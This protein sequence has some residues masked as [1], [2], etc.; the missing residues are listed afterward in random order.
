MK[1]IFVTGGLGYIGSHLCCDLLNNGYSVIVYDNLFNSDKTVVKKI[2]K[3][4]SKK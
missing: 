2:E 4:T 1:K 3:I